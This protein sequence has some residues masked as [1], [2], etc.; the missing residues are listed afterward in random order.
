MLRAHPVRRSS[1]FGC[2]AVIVRP[3]AVSIDV[4]I[5]S[6]L[7]LLRPSRTLEANTPAPDRH[8]CLQQGLGPFFARQ[9]PAQHGCLESPTWDRSRGSCSS[10]SPVGPILA[11]AEV[12]RSVGVGESISHPRMRHTRAF[13]CAPSGSRPG[14][15][16]WR[17]GWLVLGDDFEANSRGVTLS[18]SV[19]MPRAVSPHWFSDPPAPFGTDASEETCRR[20]VGL[21]SMGLGVFPARGGLPRCEHSGRKRSWS[22]ASCRA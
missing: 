6:A 3:V 8:R 5:S 17:F 2:V 18:F 15:S 9:V 11:A 12:R 1:T 4:G 19:S 10:G 14:D 16:R 7:R 22:C 13:F 21:P 20:P